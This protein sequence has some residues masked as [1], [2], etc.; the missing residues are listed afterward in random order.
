M[1]VAAQVLE[2]LSTLIGRA[3]SHPCTIGAP[4]PQ[5]SVATP[6]A[7]L[8]YER[9][10]SDVDGPGVALGQHGYTM[11]C[12]GLLYPVASGPTPTARTLSILD[13]AARVIEAV[14]NDRS[15]GGLVLDCLCA[16]DAPPP[17][18]ASTGGLQGEVTIEVVWIG[19]SAA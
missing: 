18:V 3:L 10:A 11:P 17:D 6:S 16:H 8:T 9:L 4:P 13:A 5:S 15:L 19:G 1:S 12:R 7:W 2:A 14:H